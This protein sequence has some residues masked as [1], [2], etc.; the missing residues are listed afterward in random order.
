MIINLRSNLCSECLLLI[1]KHKLFQLLL[2]HDYLCM[3]FNSD[4]FFCFSMHFFRK[5]FDGEAA[6]TV[7]SIGTS[8]LIHNG[9]Q[10]TKRGIAR[11]GIT[12]WRCQYRKCKGKARTQQIEFKEMVQMYYPHDHLPTQME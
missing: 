9:Y 8:K 1:S 2:D 4:S 11:S 3:N 5:G 12:K 7:T 6:F 10:Y